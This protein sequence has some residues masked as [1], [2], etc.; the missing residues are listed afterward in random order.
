MALFCCRKHRFTLVAHNWKFWQ[1]YFAWKYCTEVIYVYMYSFWMYFLTLTPGTEC[2]FFVFSLANP[3]TGRLSGRRLPALVQP[4]P[5]IPPH[6]HT[7]LPLILYCLLSNRLWI[8]LRLCGWKKHEH[9]RRK[10][11]ITFL[12]IDFAEMGVEEKC[13]LWALSW[14]VCRKGFFFVHW[15]QKCLQHGYSDYFLYLIFMMTWFW[16]YKYSNVQFQGVREP[17]R[18]SRL[19]STEIHRVANEKSE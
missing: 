3:S 8:H 1:M 18:P 5:P 9:C 13:W 4:P 10:R 14:R 2:N 6:T 7:H 12:F 19:R 15:T 11:K 16:Y 17:I